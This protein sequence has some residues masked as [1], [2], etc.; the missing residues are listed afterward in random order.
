MEKKLY[1][2]K[3]YFI[4]EGLLD[5]ANKIDEIS[6]VL[7]KKYA[8]QV[9]SLEEYKA[10]LVPAID[11]IINQIKQTKTVPSNLTDLTDV[12][13]RV[14]TGPPE[15]SDE[16]KRNV[17]EDRINKGHTLESIKAEWLA[18]TAQNSNSGTEWAQT[19][20]NSHL[21]P[22]EQT[23]RD[24]NYYVTLEK[25][26]QNIYNFMHAYPVLLN[27]LNFL[28]NPPKDKPPIAIAIKIPRELD[29]LL[30]HN[31]NLKI[32]YWDSSLSGTID[33]IVKKWATTWGISLSPRT[34]T[35]GVDIASTKESPGSNASYGAIISQDIAKYIAESIKAAIDYQE[36][37][38]PKFRPDPNVYFNWL[39]HNLAN[40]IIDHNNKVLSTNPISKPISNPSSSQRDQRVK[41][42]GP[43]VN[44]LNEELINYVK[45]YEGEKNIGGAWQDLFTNQIPQERSSFTAY[46]SLELIEDGMGKVTDYKFAGNKV[47]SSPIVSLTFVT[48]GASKYIDDRIINA[49]NLLSKVGRSIQY[50]YV[51]KTESRNF[52][53]LYVIV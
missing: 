18:F 34:H 8:Q 6:K 36:K 17:F 20:F 38:D 40:L 19:W 11:S 5:K 47:T 1:L 16:Q 46:D 37:L 33:N 13:Y 32:Y 23:G 9:F 43:S 27:D 41:L 15:V 29:L 45:N 7:F 52:Y 30:V 4:K 42:V 25:T 39:N 14:I 51:L 10:W 53:I 3:K 31:D 50:L 12:I 24:F 48:S 2:L 44:P 22:R 26:G 49:N 28:S 21:T 35:F